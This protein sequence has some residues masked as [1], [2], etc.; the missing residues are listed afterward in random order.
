M[1]ERWP[2]FLA[3]Y[4]DMLLIGLPAS[5]VAG[6]LFAIIF[7]GFGKW[8]AQPGAGYWFWIVVLPAVLVIEA[9][10]HD[11]FGT[12]P[13]KAL[14][15]LKVTSLRG[16][17]LGF[18]QYLRRNFALWPSGL[19]LGV[20]LISLFTYVNQYGR[21]GRGLETS[22]DEKLGTRVFG[23]P[24]GWVRQAIAIAAVVLLLLLNAALSKM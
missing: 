5:F 18:E 19:A 14:L 13:G 16:E 24:I 7:D 23:R 17:R 20:P 3:R 12:S 2:R 9:F 8:I 15:G 22:Y 10:L 4:V 11:W 1:A 6:I 21:L